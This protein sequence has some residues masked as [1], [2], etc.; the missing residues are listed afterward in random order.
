MVRMS[1]RLPYRRSSR[2]EDVFLPLLTRLVQ[3][4][5][6]YEQ[7]KKAVEI[8]SRWGAKISGDEFQKRASAAIKD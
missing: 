8:P 5:L 7:V 6:S 2:R 3:A 1:D 4:G